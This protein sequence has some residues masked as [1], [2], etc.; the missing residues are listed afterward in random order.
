MKRMSNSIF[1]GKGFYPQCLKVDTN[2][3]N[4]LK[5]R[6]FGLERADRTHDAYLASYKFCPTRHG[7]SGATNCDYA[8]G[9]SVGR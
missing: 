2:Q 9:A 6:A 1:R 3:V 5:N 8:Y 7:C 4:D